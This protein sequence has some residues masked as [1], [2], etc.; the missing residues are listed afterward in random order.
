MF[1][2]ITF[3]SSLC[4]LLRCLISTYKNIAVKIEAIASELGPDIHTPFKPKNLGNIN[5][6]GIRIITCLLKPK[7]MDILAFPIA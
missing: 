6:N 7:N 1:Y 5:N 2:I 4:N 3:T